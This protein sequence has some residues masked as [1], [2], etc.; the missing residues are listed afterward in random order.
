MKTF[1]VE[2]IF[3]STLSGPLIC[4]VICNPGKGRSLY[5]VIIY[6]FIIQIPLKSHYREIGP[7]QRRG[8]REEGK[9][10]EKI[11][12]KEKDR[13]TEGETPNPHLGELMR[14]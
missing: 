8:N 1:E 9:T 10:S 2:E 12:E 5:F 13:S 4:I 14:S 6:L 11:E 7:P 3:G